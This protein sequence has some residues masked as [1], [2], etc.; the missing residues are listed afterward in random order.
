VLDSLNKAA[1]FYPPAVTRPKAPVPFPFN[2]IKLLANNLEII[3]EEAYWERLVLATGPPRMAFCCA[4]ELVKTLLVERPNE[5]PRGR[6]QVA[7]LER[8]FGKAIVSAEGPE[9]HWQ[10]RAVAPMFRPGELA[11]YG[12]I[13]S[14][15]AEAV[16]TKWCSAAPGTVHWVHKDIKGAAFQVISKTMLAGVPEDVLDAIE[17]GLDEYY[18]HANWCVL[19]MLLGL[20]EWVPRPGGR[21]MRRDEARLHKAVADL[22]RMHR[23]AESGN[24]FLNNMLRARDPETGQTMSDDLIADNLITFTNDTRAFSLIWT[25]YLISQSPEWQERIH[26]EVERVA[27][28]DAVAAAHV[29]QLVAVRQVISESL[30]L[31]P[32]APLIIRD[33]VADL[34]FEGTTIPAGTMGMIPI[35][36]IHRHRSYWNDPDRFDPDRFAPDATS[37]P[38]RF[39]FMPFGAGPRNCIGAAFATLEA[40]IMLATFVRAVRFELESGFTPQPSAHMFLLPKNGLRLRI[41]PRNP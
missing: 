39:A 15:Q 3:P 2:L 27:G 5:F 37:K 8:L 13:M 11:R 40:T 26:R 9:W 21:R 12:P 38:A 36:A 18:T 33:I 7:I 14:A 35:Y 19:Y 23:S 1:P 34:E 4:P 22:V 32:T 31:Y 25:L 29:E 41:T 30:R 24:A 6:L 16:V 28:V 17:N 10:R 20:P